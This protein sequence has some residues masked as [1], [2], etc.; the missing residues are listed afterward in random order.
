MDY[1]IQNFVVQKGSWIAFGLLIYWALSGWDT[2]LALMKSRAARELLSR[3]AGWILTKLYLACIGL[4]TYQF[5]FPSL[6]FSPPPP[7]P[8]YSR[9]KIHSET[10]S[11]A[12]IADTLSKEI[13]NALRTLESSLMMVV[14]AQVFWGIWILGSLKSYSLIWKNQLYNLLSVIF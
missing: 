7:S 6:T 8:P 10:R 9:I 5:L 1:I 13:G 12:M 3:S 2:E 14:S 4:S 11:Y